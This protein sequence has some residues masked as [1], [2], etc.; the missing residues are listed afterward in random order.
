MTDDLK[1]KVPFTCVISGSSGPGKSSFCVRFLQNLDTLCTKSHIPGGITWCYSERAAVPSSSLAG[2]NVRFHEGVPEK[3]GDAQGGKP[4]LVI[5]DDLLNTVYL[6]QVCDLFTKGSHHRNI[7][8]ILITQNLFHQGKY[9]RDISL[10]AKYLVQLKTVRDK[11][12][13]MH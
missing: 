5:L 3:I 10:N 8:L 7:S 4:C 12:Q 2:L 13:F 6:E 9:C 1:F 11:L